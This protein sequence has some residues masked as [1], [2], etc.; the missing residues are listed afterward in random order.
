M[1]SSQFKLVLLEISKQLSKE[2]LEQMKFLSGDF[3]FKK[4][5]EKVDT[6]FRLF[7]FLM[8]RGKLG[9]DNTDFLCEMLQHI[10]RL[11]LMTKVERLPEQPGSENGTV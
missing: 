10:H 3:I 2:E 9:E 7:Q 11:D 1:S 4:D 6:G 8:E 5:M